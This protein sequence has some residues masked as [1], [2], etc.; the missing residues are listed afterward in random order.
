M[1]NPACELGHLLEA[2]ALIFVVFAAVALPPASATDLAKVLPKHWSTGVLV[3][4][5]KHPHSYDYWI[6]LEI[7]RYVGRSPKR[8]RLTM[9]T[10]VKFA[11]EGY[12][13]YIV[14]SVGVVQKTSYVEQD[15]LPP[16]SPPLKNRDSPDVG[17][18]DPHTKP[19]P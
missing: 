3:E 17:S 15:L 8:L 18:K 19:P 1:R 7:D 11:I 5:K 4:I 16:P 9:N 12:F 14:D 6:E 13:L 2:V 10:Q